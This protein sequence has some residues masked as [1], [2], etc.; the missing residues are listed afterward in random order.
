MVRDGWYYGLAGVILA[1]VLGILTGS[2]I[3][4]AI[5]LLLALFFLWFFRD[6]EREIPQGARLVVSPADGKVTAIERIQTLQGGRQRISIFLNV[7]DVHVNRAPV[8]G[9]ILVSEYKKG[10]YLNAMNPESSVR[11][12]QNVVEME[13]DDGHAV[14]FSQIA[15]LLARR[16]VFSKRAGDLVSR[17]E[18]VGMMKFGS[19]MD[20]LLPERS[21]LRV[22]LGQRVKGGSSVLAE[23]P[24]VDPPET[25]PER[26]E[27]LALAGAW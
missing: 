9:M 11:N 8:G 22:T 7:F 10:L 13:T 2:D 1:V 14:G 21:A 20:V 15:G 19:R 24:E 4:V 23:L 25:E 12:E 18:R 5:P 17:G 26:E 6:P 16:I 27:E 3:L